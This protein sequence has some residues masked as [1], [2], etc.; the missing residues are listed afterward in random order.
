MYKKQISAYKESEKLFTEFNNTLIDISL[1]EVDEAVEI[2][3][4][5]SLQLC[6][7]D[8]IAIA[9]LLENDLPLETNALVRSLMEA[10]FK[11]NWIVEGKERKEWLNR[12]YCLEAHSYFEYEKEIRS[13]EK[14]QT[15]LQFFSADKWER[16]IESLD[17]E[18]DQNPHLV[19]SYRN[20]K[21][22]FKTA[23]NFSDIMGKKFRSK[24]YHFYKFISAY[25]HHS[26]FLKTFLL[27]SSKYEWDTKRITFEPVNQS[28]SLGLLFLQNI[29]GYSIDIFS[30]Y[31]PE[32]QYNRIKIYK[33]LESLAEKRYED[34]ISFPHH[35]N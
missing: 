12:V 33:E 16:V 14:D 17:K 11:L 30:N 13:M 35:K 34:Y 6:K 5:M 2:Y 9:V 1:D 20:D 32:E 4:L 8:S 27:K 7:N 22:I 28:L 29:M 25:V 24:Y 10:Y 15:N 31:N 21:R 23:P 3:F 26:P 19:N 18:K